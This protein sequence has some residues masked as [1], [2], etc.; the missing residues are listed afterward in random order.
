MRPVIALTV[1]VAAWGMTSP[2]QARCE[3]CPNGY[4]FWHS[5]EACLSDTGSGAMVPPLYWKEDLL[6][7]IYPLP[8]K[9]LGGRV[10]GVAGPNG[11]R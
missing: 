7:E 4:T 9:R 8:G 2:A 10:G 6:R 1:L 11:D 3:A 5:R